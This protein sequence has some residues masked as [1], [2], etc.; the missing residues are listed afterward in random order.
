MR[1]RTS[2]QRTDN[3]RLFVTLFD[4][5]RL[6]AAPSHVSHEITHGLRFRCRESAASLG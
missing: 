4:D 1:L 2:S 3:V 5:S 6:K